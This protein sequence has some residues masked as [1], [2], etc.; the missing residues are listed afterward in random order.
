[1]TKRHPQADPTALP[2]NF[3]KCRAYGHQWNPKITT[4]ETYGRVRVRETSLICARCKTT[5]T[6]VTSTRGALLPNREVE[7]PKG[8]LLHGIKS[9]KAWNM[10]VRLELTDRILDGKE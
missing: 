3:L 10:E 1:M 5:K 8:Y 9:R 6:Q 4:V 7:Y 2:T